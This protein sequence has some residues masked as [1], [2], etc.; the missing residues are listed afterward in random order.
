MDIRT[1]DV[2]VD[3]IPSIVRSTGDDSA[4][5]AVV[6]VH[7]NPG[8][9]DDFVGLLPAV[10]D[11]ARAVA[12][13][14]PG[15]GKAGRPRDFEYTIEGYSRHLGRL[16]DA[17]GIERVHLALHDFGG[18]WGLHWASQHPDRVR[19]LVLF[20]VGVLPGYRWHKFARIWRTPVLGE[21]FQLTTT[22]AV[23]RRVLDAH[24]PKPFPREFHD[25]VFEYSDWG[26]K[27]AV[28]RLYRA[29]DDIGAHSARAGEVLRPRHMPALV[30]W[31]DGD[32]FLPV[33]FA[34]RQKDYF[35][36]QVHVLPRCG[37]WPMIDE[38]DRVRELVVAFLRDRLRTQPA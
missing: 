5:E 15:Y 4:R 21:L 16:L 2:A 26:M 31:G 14:M 29:T 9:S 17:L 27:R 23:Q 7:G 1:R 8:S 30:V 34:Q 35:D 12:P 10:G 13:D 20:N 38:P 22:R 36:A 6:F 24:N 33:Q 19:S 18:A 37:H 25:R 3:G 28:L 11:L 32:P